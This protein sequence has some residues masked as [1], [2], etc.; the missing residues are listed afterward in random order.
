MKELVKKILLSKKTR[1]VKLLTIL[2]ASANTS[3]NPWQ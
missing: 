3:F 1:Q 2:A